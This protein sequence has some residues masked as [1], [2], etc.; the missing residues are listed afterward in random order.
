MKIKIRLHRIKY[1]IVF[2]TLNMGSSSIV[3]LGSLHYDIF[4]KSNAIPKIGETVLAENWFPKL[5]GKGANQT[6]ALNKELIKVKFISAI[7]DDFFSEF[8]LK[9]L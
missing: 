5:G 2:C 9:R 6:V 3:V 7:G 8:L 1:L 4:I